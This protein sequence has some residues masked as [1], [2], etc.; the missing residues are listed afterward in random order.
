MAEEMKR[1]IAETLF[2][3][4]KHKNIEKISVK[5]VI[6]E[7]GISRTTFYYYFDDIFDAVEWLVSRNLEQITNEALK[8]EDEREALQYYVKH[9][10][11]ICPVLNKVKGTKLYEAAEGILNRTVSQYIRQAV[12]LTVVAGVVDIDEKEIEIYTSILTHGITGYLFENCGRANIDQD[13]LVEYLLRIFHSFQAVMP[14]AVETA[15]HL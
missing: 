10:I 11:G 4:T 13:L 9:T 7:C 3:L 14:S 8:I 6:D 12:V 15:E 2:E 5:D 1:K